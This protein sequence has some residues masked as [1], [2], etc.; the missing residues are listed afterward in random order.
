MP[1]VVAVWYGKMADFICKVRESFYEKV[2]VENFLIVESEGKETNRV[3]SLAQV[4]LRILR[5][6]DQPENSN[7]TGKVGEA[8]P[9]DTLFHVHFFRKEHSLASGIVP[10]GFAVTLQN[11][12]FLEREAETFA[13]I[14]NTPP[15]TQTCELAPIAGIAVCETAVI[16]DGI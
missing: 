11:I 5:E 4:L 16:R 6:T 7:E 13:V 8:I 15:A 3:I 12:S 10:N 9:T 1:N 14:F 2:A